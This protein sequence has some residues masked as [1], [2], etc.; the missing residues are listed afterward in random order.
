MKNI[1]AP[2]H[3]S[4]HPCSRSLGPFRVSGWRVLR[5]WWASNKVSLFFFFFFCIARQW[6]QP[7][8]PHKEF[9]KESFHWGWGVLVHVYPVYTSWPGDVSWVPPEDAAP[10]S[11]SGLFLA[12]AS[13]WRLLHFGNT[14]QCTR[15]S[16]SGHREKHRGG[17]YL[18][19]NAVFYIVSQC[20]LLFPV[21]GLWHPS[22][23]KESQ[24][25][26]LKS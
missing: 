10:H 7:L 22:Q 14:L 1:R 13:V 26:N 11:Q 3:I 8:Q 12:I 17:F 16:H 15:L 24:P 9:Q 20:S 23:I 5:K 2:F 21:I 25:F 6:A 4:T 19:R 18:K